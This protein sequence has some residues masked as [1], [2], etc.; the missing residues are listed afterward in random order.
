MEFFVPFE[1]FIN[2]TIQKKEFAEILKKEKTSL[3]IKNIYTDY[4]LKNKFDA[5]IG[6]NISVKNYSKIIDYYYIIFINSKYIEIY[7]LSNAIFTCYTKLMSKDFIN[8]LITNIIYKVINKMNTDELK[9]IQK[10]N[11]Y[12]I[13]ELN[14]DEF[15][16]ITIDVLLNKSIPELEEKY[17]LKYKEYNRKKEYYI[18]KYRNLNHEIFIELNK[19]MIL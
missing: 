3:T 12:S 7:F 10:I 5:F 18:K 6:K 14:E 16:E 19:K 2:T 9:N 8:V 11:F 17:Q 4:F 13:P 1:E 15:K